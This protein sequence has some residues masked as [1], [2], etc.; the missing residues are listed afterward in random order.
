MSVCFLLVCTVLL[1]SS[2]DDSIKI[3]TRTSDLSA[4]IQ[5]VDLLTLSFF[6]S[7]V[8]VFMYENKQNFAVNSS[9][10]PKFLKKW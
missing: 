8:V 9:R 6:F 7:S 5:M 2:S 1:H 10:V 3:H 4:D